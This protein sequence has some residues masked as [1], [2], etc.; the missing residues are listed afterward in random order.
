MF[1]APILFLSLAI[2]SAATDTNS[3]VG[4]A[5]TG[6]SRHVCCYPPVTITATFAVV[7]V[8]DTGITFLSP[9]ALQFFMTMNMC[10]KPCFAISATWFACC[11]SILVMKGHEAEQKDA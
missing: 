3:T 9:I 7:G 8:D 6:K 2:L 11:S 10:E 4:G 5:M 1:M